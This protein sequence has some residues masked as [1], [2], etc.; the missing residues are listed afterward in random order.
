MTQ[1]PEQIAAS[2]SEAQRNYLIDRS[3]SSHG[4]VQRGLLSYRWGNNSSFGHKETPL[5]QQVRA[6]LKEQTP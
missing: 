4:L 2:L 3:G 6:I 1:T 5:G